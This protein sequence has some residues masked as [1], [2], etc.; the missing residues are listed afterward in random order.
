[1]GV[2]H[3]MNVDEKLDRFDGLL[4][5]YAFSCDVANQPS[6]LL[7][8]IARI[9]Q[10]LEHDPKELIQTKPFPHEK[11]IEKSL[12]RAENELDEIEKSVKPFIERLASFLKI[13]R[14]I[15]LLLTSWKIDRKKIPTESQSFSTESE[16]RML[17]A[18]E[19]K[20]SELESRFVEISNI[21]VRAS[22]LISR[23]KVLIRNLKINPKEF[24][25]NGI[26][27]SVNEKFL[28]FV[29]QT[30][31]NFEER[32]ETQNFS[33]YSDAR[34]LM[35]INANLEKILQKIPEEKLEVV[36]Q[37]LKLRK[38]AEMERQSIKS[39]PEFTLA[40]TK[41]LSLKTLIEE[42]EELRKIEGHMGTVATTVYLEAWVPKNCLAKVSN[43][44]KKA[45]EGKCIIKD[46]P[47]APEDNVPTMLKPAPRI[48]EAFEKLT[49]SF[50]Y[51]KPDEINPVF[52]MAIT[53]PLLFG[54]MF[55]DVGQ[56]IILVI[57]GLLLSYFRRRV[58]IEEVG[59]IIRYL[60]M[61]SGLIVL[62]GIASIFFGF[63]FGEFFGPSG[64]IH[65][66]TL[67][68][69]GPFQIGGFDPMME[70]VTMLRLA[71][72]VGVGL[73]S[74]SLVLRIINNVRKNQFRRILISI[75]WLWLLLGGFALWIY[76][77]G[78]SNLTKWFGEGLFMF[79]S[80]VVLPVLI[81]GVTTAATES[82]MGGIQFSIEILIES[83]DHT[84][85]FGRLAALSLTHSALNY[86]FL[87]LG[88]ADHSYF[89]LQSIPL[90]MIGTVIAL[91]IE[92]LIIF[93]HTL[94]LHWVE[95]L[96]GFY[97]GK[98]IPFKPIKLNNNP[99]E[100][101]SHGS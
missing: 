91:T 86:M 79:V 77:G 88:G 11:T 22:K 64:I 10:T 43:G 20:L 93:V 29:E 65:P 37:T 5:Q 73:L 67:V 71:I 59:D 3:C 28:D 56:G 82:I 21:L 51:P 45:T 76:W 12:A 35:I 101:Y 46:E 70:P 16:D 1:M 33:G 40:L 7:A 36:K 95:W 30:L 96:P 66:V 99:T 50:G 90:V 57:G 89:S 9:L 17:G 83:L 25:T 49:F 15:D 13:T 48:L 98:G 31:L 75:S 54:I 92:G 41:L 19:E 18:T 60:L 34:Q 68:K 97:S 55:A 100:Q 52:I 24:P 81:I 62:C 53:F 61:G 14:R 27:C 69:I 80:L 63:L 42:V 47:P 4:E 87:I 72:F 44:I 23:T 84:I 78:I 39:R 8:R 32:V 74:L 26:S 58:R 85:S 94:R 2:V 38:R 6:T